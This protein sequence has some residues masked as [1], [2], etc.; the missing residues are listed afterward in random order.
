M[1]ILLAVKCVF[2]KQNL[3]YKTSVRKLRNILKA[4][5]NAYQDQQSLTDLRQH[6]SFSA[7]PECW[8]ANVLT[9]HL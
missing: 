2:E 1:V 7:L 6:F 9:H 3:P 4:E 5:G 8:K